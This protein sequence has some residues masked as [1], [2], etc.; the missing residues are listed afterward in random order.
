MTEAW[1][2]V[3]NSDAGAAPLKQAGRGFVFMK[4]ASKSA[5]AHRIITESAA[6]PGGMTKDRPLVMGL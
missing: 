6:W 1:M 3:E 2:G 5:P 4:R